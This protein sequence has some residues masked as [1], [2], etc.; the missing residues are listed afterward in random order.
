[1]YVRFQASTRPTNFQVYQGRGIKAIDGDV[2]KVS[3]EL[4]KSL[5]ND[6]PKNFFEA[7]E[8]EFES[9]L[10]SRP[11]RARRSVE[12]DKKETH[13]LQNEFRKEEKKR[14]AAVEKPEGFSMGE[15]DAEEETEETSETVQPEDGDDEVAISDDDEDSDEGDSDEEDP[16]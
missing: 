10:T 2:K 6:F 8:E 14:K 5:I 7:T 13:R 11:E 1:M 9:F 3:K 4:G 15:E 16:E 12:G